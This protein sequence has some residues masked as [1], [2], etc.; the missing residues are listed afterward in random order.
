MIDPS[1][2]TEP[3]IWALATLEQAMPNAKDAMRTLTLG[4]GGN[5]RARIWIS[6]N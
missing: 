4:K 6:P 5:T 3:K 1:A 2:L